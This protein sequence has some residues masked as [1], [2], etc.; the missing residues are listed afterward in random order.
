MRKKY[1][2]PNVEVVTH[3]LTTSILAGTNGTGSSGVGGDSETAVSGSDGPSE[4]GAKQN[5]FAY[6]ENWDD[7][8]EY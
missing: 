7:E 1:V 3:V 4:T 5:Q 2:K 8:E 6:W